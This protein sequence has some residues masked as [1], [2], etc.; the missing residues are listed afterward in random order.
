MKNIHFK[1]LLPF[2]LSIFLAMGS[3]AAEAH[4]GH[5]HHGGYHR[6]YHGGYHHGRHGGY[7]HRGTYYRYYHN[8]AYYNNCRLVG[9]YW[10]YGVYHPARQVCW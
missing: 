9:G 2:L 3:I 6:G 4:G 5:G 7:Y 1:W 8:G 10:S